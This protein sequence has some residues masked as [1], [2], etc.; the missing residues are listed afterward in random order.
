MR[1]GLVQTTVSAEPATCSLSNQAQPE[2]I[3]DG[4]VEAMKFARDLVAY[5]ERNGS[6][7]QHW[8]VAV[9]VIALLFLGLGLLMP[10]WEVG[11]W[12]VYSGAAGLRIGYIALAIASI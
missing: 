2:E 10:F 4:S 3:G 7:L 11:V 1:E 6:R 9:R 5:Y 8:S 12:P